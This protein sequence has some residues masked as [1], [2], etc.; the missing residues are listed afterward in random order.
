MISVVAQL[1][2]T[3]PRTNVMHQAGISFGKIRSVTLERR[4]GE[5][6]RIVGEAEGAWRWRH[7]TR[8]S[9]QEAVHHQPTQSQSQWSGSSGSIQPW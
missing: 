3:T 7:T 8:L 9:N 1:I 6:W 4:S 2:G 5:L